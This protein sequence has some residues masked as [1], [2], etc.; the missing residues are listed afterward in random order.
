MLKTII[1]AVIWPPPL[2]A[3]SLIL[4]AESQG[5]PLFV[6]ALNLQALQAFL[7]PRQGGEAA[8][9]TFSSLDP[10]S[11]IPPS[12]SVLFTLGSPVAVPPR[13]HSRPPRSWQQ[14]QIGQSQLS[15]WEQ[16]VLLWVGSGADGGL[17]VGIFF[18]LLMH[19]SRQESEGMITCGQA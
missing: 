2:S 8:D 10:S 11:F 12:P 3:Q 6:W 13:R 16:E 19:W 1:S 9:S 15:P 4:W 17:V 18:F 7:F 5:G 14:P